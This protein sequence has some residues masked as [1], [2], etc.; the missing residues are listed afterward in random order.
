[1][2]A[3]DA[4]TPQVV[5]ANG[6]TLAAATFNAVTQ[7]NGSYFLNDGSVVLLAKNASGGASRTVT[8]T[9]AANANN[10]TGTITRT[11]AN[12]AIAIIVPQPPR[13]YNQIGVGDLGKVFIDYDSDDGLTIAAISLHL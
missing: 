7:A 11:V 10:R 3:R 6:G 9:S 2:A 1:M 5:A 8:V 13:L 4:I 12:G